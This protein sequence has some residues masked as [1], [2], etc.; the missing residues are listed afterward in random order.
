MVI[1]VKVIIKEGNKINRVFII[2][3]ICFILRNLTLPNLPDFKLVKLVKL[4]IGSQ[5]IEQSQE[6]DFD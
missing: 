1:K 6:P 2:K 4:V 3:I 5:I